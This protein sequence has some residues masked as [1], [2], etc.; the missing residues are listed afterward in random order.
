MYVSKQIKGRSSTIRGEYLKG[1]LPQFS[2]T[3]DFKEAHYRKFGMRIDKC[4]YC[5]DNANTLDHLYSPIKNKKLTGYTNEIQNLV[6]CCGPCNSS[7]GNKNWEDW[8]RSNCKRVVLIMKKENFKER[9]EIIQNYEKLN[10]KSIVKELRE[11]DTTR[12]EKKMNEYL[13]ILQSM[14]DEDS[15]IIKKYFEESK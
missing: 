15:L 2:Y 8:L 4:A 11:F 7:K 3:D 9:I 6:P 1:I 14:L 13:D 10:Q 5:G 12:F